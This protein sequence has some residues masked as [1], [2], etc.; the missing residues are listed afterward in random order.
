VWIAIEGTNGAGKTHLARLLEQQMG[1]GCV[2]LDEL[3]DAPRDRLPGQVIAALNAHQDPFLRTGHPLAETFALLAL[4]VRRREEAPPGTALV[5]ED[6]GIDSVA[7]YQAITLADHTGQDAYSLT[8]RL[9]ALGERWRP[10]NTR[11]VL[12]TDT[13]AACRARWTARLG[14][15]LTDTERTYLEHAGDLYDRLAND[16]PDRYT[17]L[18]RSHMTPA[19]TLAAL[20]RVCRTA[21]PQGGPL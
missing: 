3:P 8:R 6:R 5:V 4:A 11:T 19:Q 9:L 1:G 15:E 10:A 13:P 12:L 21:C 7:V 16:E 17:V 18:D 20:T 14:R 2:L